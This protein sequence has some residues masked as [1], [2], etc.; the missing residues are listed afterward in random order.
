M[1]DETAGSNTPTAPP[2]MQNAAQAESISVERL[3]NLVAAGRL[4]MPEFQRPFGWDSRDRRDLLDSV[5]R[6]YPVGTLLLWKNPPSGAQRGRALYAEAPTPAQGD[7]YVVV[8]GQ[9]RITTLWEALGERPRR[10]TSGMVFDMQRDEFVARPL[11]DGELEG[12]SPAMTGEA[13]P[14]VPLYLIRDAATLSE[15]VPP[16]LPR[17]AKRRYF[18]LGRRIREYTLALYVVEDADINVLVRVFDRVNTSGRPMSREDVFNALVGSRIEE[19]GSVGL[20]L[21]NARVR[22]LGFGSL[23]P[24]TILKAFEAIRG[25]KVGRLDPRK[26]DVRAAEADLR[27]TGEAF[28][29][30][31][32]FLQ[33]SAAVP[34]VEICPYELPLVVLARFFACHRSPSERSLILLRR[35]FWR[36]SIAERLGGASG[37]MQQHVDD[38]AEKD[39]DG[40]VQALLR[41]TGSARDVST[42]ANLTSGFSL[43]SARGQMLVCALLAQRP[44]HLVTG[45]RLSPSDL[46]RDGKADVLRP[47]ARPADDALR[48]SLVNKLLHPATKEKPAQL[49]RDAS[50]EGALLSHGIEREGA[51]LLRANDL[52]AFLQRRQ[53]TLMRWVHAF[54]EC[55]AEVERDDAPPISALARRSA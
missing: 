38:I 16:G 41:R 37:T 34:H 35:W 25:D 21:V 29:A 6:G 3:L 44:R 31:I 40:S 5:Y 12:A 47:I 8:D 1:V 22:G 46:F 27:R 28:G 32:R 10:G 18:E 49:I 33:E 45:E 55:Q 19:D 9:Q 51:A 23:K 13:L 39:E 24:A 26:L 43:A 7:T 42:D 50:D 54:L 4:R 52:H 48:G 11:T 20:E 15:W 2:R 53:S 17:E 30:V 36:G 14:Q